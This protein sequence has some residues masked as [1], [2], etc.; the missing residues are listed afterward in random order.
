LRR[1]EGEERTTGSE[2]EGEERAAG[3]RRLVARARGRLPRIRRRE[4]M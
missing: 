3:R 2:R 4:K 1:R